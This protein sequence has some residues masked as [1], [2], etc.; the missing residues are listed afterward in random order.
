MNAAGSRV[1]PPN[2]TVRRPVRRHHGVVGQRDG[3]EHRLFHLLKAAVRLAAAVGV[4]AHANV[5]REL[6]GDVR[7][8]K[9]VGLHPAAVGAGVS[10]EVYQQRPVLPDGFGARR[11]VVVHDPRELAVGRHRRE[12]RGRQE[13]L[14]LAEPPA[15]EAG[16]EPDRER[17]R[18]DGHAR[19]APIV[20]G[21]AAAHGRVA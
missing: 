5:A 12:V 4:E 7:P 21:R 11:I 10:R 9:H 8:R 16:R 15:G 18:G 17:R 2:A 3:A 14:E 6:A 13:R 19:A 20:A 1:S